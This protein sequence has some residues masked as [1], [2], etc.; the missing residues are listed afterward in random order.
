MDKHANIWEFG[1]EKWRKKKR[2]ADGTSL[3]MWPQTRKFEKWN[4]S[5]W[6]KVQHFQAEIQIILTSLLFSNFPVV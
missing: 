6:F 1:L 4:L 2:D 3:K 5:A